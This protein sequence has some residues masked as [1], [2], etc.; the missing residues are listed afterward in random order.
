MA[1]WVKHRS[2]STKAP[3]TNDKY[4]DSAR[5]IAE[6]PIGKMLASDVHLRDVDHLWA[7]LAVPYGQASLNM[8]RSHLGMAFRF[9]IKHGY[10]A[11]NPVDGSEFPGS[12]RPPKDL[13]WLDAEEFPRMREHLKELG[14]PVDVALLVILLCGLRPGE[15]LAL[16]WDAIDFDRGTIKVKRNVQRSE[17]GRLRKVVD[18]TKTPTGMRTVEMPLDLSTR[19]RRL[20][21]ERPF[22]PMFINSQR[23]PLNFHNMRQNGN[24]ACA[25]IGA[26]H[27]TPHGFRHS[28]GSYLLDRGMKPAAVAQ[29]LGHTLSVFMKTYA[30]KMRDVMSTAELLGDGTNG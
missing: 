21:Q 1:G 8:L 18:Y 10:C 12:V 25:A 7:A 5:I 2:G 27:V 15:V 3:M 4:Q 14:K 17:N 19:L 26:G 24:K 16:Q 28:N 11:I 13:D 29:H 6:Q 22:G 20:H 23:H 30:H 9:G